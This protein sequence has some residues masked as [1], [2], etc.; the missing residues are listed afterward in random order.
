MVLCE[1][2]PAPIITI[3]ASAPNR[4]LVEI[5]MLTHTSASRSR[6]SIRQD[7][8]LSVPFVRWARIAASA[9]GL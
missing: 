4:N 2:A 5:C 8:V 6:A 3:S 9:A 1:R 7:S